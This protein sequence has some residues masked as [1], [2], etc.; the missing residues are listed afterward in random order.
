MLL[1]VGEALVDLVIAPDGTVDAALGGAPFNTARAASRV[2]ADVEFGGALS[3]DRF[4]TMLARQLG[5]DGVW[6]SHVHHTAAPTTLAAAE[7]DAD[8]VATYRFY[9]EATSA[10]EYAEWPTISP[11]AVFTGGLGLVFEPMA[12]TVQT[13]VLATNRE[14]LVM[15]DVNA[16]PLVIADR[17]GY[18]ERLSAVLRRADVVKVSDEDLAYLGPDISVRSM[19]DRGAGAVI[20]T[21]GSEATAIYA[22]TRSVTVPVPPP[23]API[24]DTIGA[25]DTFGGAVIAELLRGG[26]RPADIR[27]SQGVD[28]LAHAVAFGTAAAGIVVTRRGA[29]PPRRNEL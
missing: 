21:A 7:I 12:D 10:P 5:D 11:A 24:V 4:G 23:P 17:M 22:D 27:S 15:V 9:I 16:R 28:L 1:V 25:G 29:D 19:L 14:C 2:G 20:V 13:G 26:V 6:L 18:L 3:D 8:G